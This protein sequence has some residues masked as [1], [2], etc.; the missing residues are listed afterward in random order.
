[1]TGDPERRVSQPP[2]AAPPAASVETAAQQRMVRQLLSHART[3]LLAGIL[4]ACVIAVGIWRTTADSGIF[5]WL[6]L[7]VGISLLRL[8]AIAPLRHA[9]DRRGATLA[10]AGFALGALVG[11]AVWAGLVLFDHPAQPIGVRLLVLLMLIGVPI[12][13]LASHA[14]YLP[15]F[16]AF[17]A[18][19]VAAMLYWAWVLGNG[20]VWEFLLLAVA[21]TSLVVMI[22][23]GYGTS[24]R[25]AL[26]RDIENERLL[27]ELQLS[28]DDL[29]ELAYRDPLTGLA[30]RRRFVET[31]SSLLGRLRDGDLLTLMLIDVDDFKWINDN[32]G[33]AAGDQVLI[34][35]SRRI[36][37]RSRVNEIIA[38]TLV[39]TARIGGDE[40]I[41]VFRLDS[42]D[43]VEPLAS[44]LLEALTAPM[45]VGAAEYR[46]RVSIGIALA[47]VHARDLEG[48]QHAADR[49]MYRA[50]HAGGRRF[51]IAEV[52]DG[53]SSPGGT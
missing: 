24:L 35:M 50:K 39:D 31:T 41:A 43:A 13:S 47:P 49:A 23:R 22:A 21:Y 32:H 9:I 5:Y 44:R 8:A 46:P 2:N 51:A 17:G 48:L 42:A 16:Y 27:H 18:P 12:T 6:M 52:G 25:H 37:A 30:N 34:E 28:N 14:A 11:G 26:E 1:M 33:H 10:G 20:L 36:E 40:F 38:C 19:I 53:T 15:A 3:T 45:T 4:V 7:L 29:Q